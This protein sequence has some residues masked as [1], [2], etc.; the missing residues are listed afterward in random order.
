MYLL[1]AQAVHHTVL[2]GLDNHY[3]YRA[4]GLIAVLNSFA[5]DSGVTG[6]LLV[7]PAGVLLQLGPW[8]IAPAGLD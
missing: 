4:A 2:V 6:S 3:V 7:S 5:P 1:D 8:T